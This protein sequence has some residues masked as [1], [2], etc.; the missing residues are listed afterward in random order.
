MEIIHTR[1]KSLECTTLKTTHLKLVCNGMMQD[2]R[3]SGREKERRCRVHG[4]YC[5]RGRV[6]ER[7]VHLE[8]VGGWEGGGRRP[9]WD[10][11]PS[12]LPCSP[13]ALNSNSAAAAAFLG[14][15]ARAPSALSPAAS[16]A[17]WQQRMNYCYQPTA[18]TWRHSAS[19]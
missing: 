14:G 13:H 3:R 19:W 1:P 6:A 8:E 11:A 9:E 10:C 4:D 17:D 5:R 12:S 16:Q 2:S 18:T 7:L 15:S